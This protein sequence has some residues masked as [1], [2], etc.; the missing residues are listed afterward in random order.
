MKTRT[1]VRRSKRVRRPKAVW[2]TTQC[3]TTLNRAFLKK[4]VCSNVFAIYVLQ[5][6]F[7][8][9]P[10]TKV[11]IV[12]SGTLRQRFKQHLSKKHYSEVKV[13]CVL[14]LGA[15]RASGRYLCPS[16]VTTT[17]A[18]ILRQLT[19]EKL[20]SP[21]PISGGKGVCETEVVLREN[22]PRALELIGKYTSY[23]ETMSTAKQAVR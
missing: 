17:E 14:T 13:L 8:G 5:L 22:E 11:G 2:T 4:S 20:L 12:R 6:L 19:S 16:I 10:M 18:Q 9:K 3:A 15:T 23:G 21:C 7:D 1:R